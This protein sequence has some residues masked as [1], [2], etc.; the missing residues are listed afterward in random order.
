MIKS[1]SD[2]QS[3]SMP[4]DLP[5][6]ALVSYKATRAELRALLG[7]PHY[8]ETD[9][10]RTCGGEQDAWAYKLSSGQRVFVLLDV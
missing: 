7:P 10:R 4:V 2:M 1:C 5:I 6:W 9:P 8:I 3:L